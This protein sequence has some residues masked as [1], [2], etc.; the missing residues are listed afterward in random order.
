M[1]QVSYRD[2]KSEFNK[3]DN[4]DPQ[5]TKRI[6]VSAYTTEGSLHNRLGGMMGGP[7]IKGEKQ[8]EQGSFTM[9]AKGGEK[10]FDAQ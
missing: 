10:L 2:S 3:Q 9:D 5:P 1:K 8:I 7:D 4:D 6:S